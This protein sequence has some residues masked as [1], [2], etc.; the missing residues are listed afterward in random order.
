MCSSLPLSALICRRGNVLSSQTSRIRSSVPLE[1]HQTDRCQ[2]G[3][4]SHIWA[5]KHRHSAEGSSAAHGEANLAVMGVL[6]AVDD[7]AGGS[8]S[9]EECEP[10]LFLLI[11][12]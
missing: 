9:E 8:G 10:A 3:S 1:A 2:S 12:E 7:A 5:E 11:D 6:I 4:S